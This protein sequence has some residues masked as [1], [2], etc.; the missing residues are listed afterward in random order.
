VFAREEFKDIEEQLHLVQPT[1]TYMMSLLAPDELAVLLEELN[2]PSKQL[3]AFPLND[4]S[5]AAVANCGTHWTL[6]LYR[7]GRFELYDSMGGTYGGSVLDM[8]LHSMDAVGSHDCWFEA[9]TL[10]CSICVIQLHTSLGC[11][12]SY[13]CQ[14]ESCRNTEGLG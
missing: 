12:C 11:P 14:H 5:D 6:L 10:E 8:I 4:S 3:I 2:L 7:E 1:V 9:S 13:P